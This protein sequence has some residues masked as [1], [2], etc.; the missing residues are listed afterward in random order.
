MFKLTIFKIK[1][2]SNISLNKFNQTSKQK[3]SKKKVVTKN[4]WCIT[5]DE[6]TQIRCEVWCCYGCLPSNM[7]RLSA[8][9]YRCDSYLSIDQ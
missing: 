7:K 5:S 3:P 8:A 2:N 1:N 9:A 4:G 6:A